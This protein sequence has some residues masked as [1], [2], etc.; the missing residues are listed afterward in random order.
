MRSNLSEKAITFSLP[1]VFSVTVV[2]AFLYAYTE[3]ILSL[4]SIFT[5]FLVITFFF[6]FDVISRAEKGAPF[7]FG[8]LLAAVSLL[9][10]I[11][12]FLSGDFGMGFILWF[13]SGNVLEPT[14]PIYLA[15]F[16]PAFS[17]F[18][19]STV[20]YF[21]IRI[22]RKHW[23]LIIGLLPFTA[24]VKMVLT[25][26]AVFMILIAAEELLI[27][28]QNTRNAMK[29][30]KAGGKSVFVVYADF[31]IALILAA[32]IFP[33]PT[34]APYYREFERA[35]GRFSLDYNNT[36]RNGRLSLRSGNA[37]SLNRSETRLLY[38]ANLPVYDYLKLQSY[39]Y[40]D[41]DG[42][43]WY[44]SSEGADYGLGASQAV[45]NFDDLTAAINDAARRDDTLL[46]RYNL[47]PDFPPEKV[48]P[49]YH[50]VIT[51]RG[52]S[53]VFAPSP[54][55]TDINIETGGSDRFYQL[56]GGGILTDRFLPQD[57]TL[58]ADYFAPYDGD[59]GYYYELSELSYEKYKQFL[60]DVMASLPANSSY[61][62]V[63][64]GFFKAHTEA[65]N[66][67]DFNTYQSPDLSALAANITAGE[68][69]LAGKAQA[70]EDFFNKGDFVYLLGYDAV[71]D[72]P[73]SFVFEG[74][75][76]SCSDFATAFTLLAGYAG[77]SVRYTEGYIPREVDDVLY[78][79]NAAY[80]TSS[81]YEIT[82]DDA[83]AYPEVYINGLWRTFEPTVATLY[84]RERTAYG[85][86]LSDTDNAL[87]VAYAMAAAIMGVLAIV[88]IIL[89]PVFAE[90][91]FQL[92]LLF[93]LKKSG[94]KVALLMLFKRICAVLDRRHG[95]SAEART[96]EEVR[97]FV[98]QH[99]G[100]DIGA[101]TEP[102]SAALYGNV[103][104]NRNDFTTAFDC[105]KKTKLKKS[106]RLTNRLSRGIIIL[107]R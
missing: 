35:L 94:R 15:A 30:R 29:G 37:D 3:E 56:F 67:K 4:W 52:Y 12:L 98:G 20:Y 97:F 5:I 84:P 101:I 75:M 86:D 90:A 96:P 60:L 14:R 31:A 9:F 88:L 66:W 99:F 7:L 17:F 77:L 58:E 22:Y 87:A 76:G 49:V 61:R 42:D 107:D 80:G 91:Y 85:N 51:A 33:K 6:M 62:E 92:T 16:I 65:M 54:S 102:L 106:S 39:P 48:D 34:Q 57:V 38:T 72:S 11:T 28:L 69:T 19:S 100:F 59:Y 1:A 63:T 23:L 70:I 93:A 2:L 103:H 71:D 95:Y 78:F 74:K 81:F 50:G 41:G 79:D 36:D 89:R 8:G 21:A 18:V 45:L 73:E 13:F 105:Y 26:P 10:F 43:F 64:E 83:H 40:Y 47:T 55:R 46:S 53:S 104:I 82:S 27:Y 32:A 24:Y 44:I 68:T 25:P